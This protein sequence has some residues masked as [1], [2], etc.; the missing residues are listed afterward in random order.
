MGQPAVRQIATMR[1]DDWRDRLVELHVLTEHGDSGAGA[2]ATAWLAADEHARWAWDTVQRTCDE[3]RRSAGAD[4][5]H[6]GWPADGA[7]PTSGRS[8]DIEVP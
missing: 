7:E 4:L 5:T 6:N 1:P 2:A 3:V 8:G